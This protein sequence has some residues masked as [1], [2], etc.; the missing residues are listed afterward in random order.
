MRRKELTVFTVIILLG[1]ICGIVYYL[2]MARHAGVL[3]KQLSTKQKVEDFRYAYNILKENFPYFEIEKNKSGF[4]WLKNKWNFEKQVKATKNDLEFYK[5]M[6]S[7]FTLV[8]NGHTNIIPPSD[9][10][11]Y[12]NNLSSSSNW[13]KVI[14]SPKVQE[15]K[16]Y[17]EKLLEDA[18]TSYF[19]PIEFVYIEGKYVSNGV[20]EIYANQ[21][22][23]EDYGIPEGSILNKINS[24]NV[25]DYVKNQGSKRYLG[26]DFLRNKAKISPLFIRDSK[27][28][29]TSLSLQLL[30]G[31]NVER[32]IKLQKFPLNNNGYS[33]STSSLT[34]KI[35]MQDK[36]ACMKV[37]SMNPDYLVSDMVKVQDFCKKIQ[38]YPY[39]IIDIR[40][41][42][43]GTDDYWQRAIM[44]PLVNEALYSNKYILLKKGAYIQPF[45]K[46][47]LFGQQV[48]PIK[49][50]PNEINSPRWVYE[51]FNGF[52][53][54]NQT[55]NGA[56]QTGYK[57]EIYLLV[58]DYVYSSAESFAAFVKSTKF[59]ILVG[60][61]TGGDGVGFSPAFASLPNSG[62]LFRFPLS[63]GLNS[64][65]TINEETHT[66]PDILVEQT[67]EDFLNFLKWRANHKNEIINPYDT[68]LNEVLKMAK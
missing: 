44:A 60:T 30:N 35:L 45:I 11:M 50:L 31:Q 48:N 63:M 10:S 21:Y 7:I 20:P 36:V 65:G 52:V 46:E 26:F 9:I 51:S 28:G 62:I 56:S 49:E 64:D 12:V 13:S 24:V 25:D 67:Y 40:G 3:R 14:N 5:T 38:Q 54:I 6:S 2:N 53:N 43:G 68:V 59:A 66:K 15:N 1:T 4:D 37:N 18:N 23:N 47:M 55:I 8:Q 22:S 16:E 39:L 32:K 41:N 57:G 42:G 17:W 29:V 19:I 33:N 34:T 27:E 58:D 61:T